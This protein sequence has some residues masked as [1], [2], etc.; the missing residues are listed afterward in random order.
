M[1]QSG[2]GVSPEILEKLEDSVNV[3]FDPGTVPYEVTL[4]L[5]PDVV[6]YF[7]RRPIAKSQKLYKQSD[8]SAELIVKITTPDEI[9]PIVKWYLPSIRIMEPEE[10]KNDFESMLQEYLENRA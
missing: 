8:G 6:V 5:D 2:F 1:E 10:L 3:W 7:E 9:L 4:W